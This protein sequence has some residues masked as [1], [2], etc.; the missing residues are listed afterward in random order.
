M[1]SLKRYSERLAPRLGLTPAALYE[2]QRQL[3]R[4]GLISEPSK[5][6]PGAGV[7]ATPENVALLLLSVMVSDSLS[8]TAKRILDET[9]HRSLSGRCPLTRA[10]R[11]GDALTVILSDLTIA[12]RVQSVSLMRSL[13]ASITFTDDEEFHQGT[14]WNTIHMSQFGAPEKI[15]DTAMRTSVTVDG[16]FLRQVADELKED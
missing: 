10:M 2:R 9:R 16:Q 12:I 1:D 14:D 15:F 4:L 13:T 3:V 7:R 11:F 5:M 6:G 8:E